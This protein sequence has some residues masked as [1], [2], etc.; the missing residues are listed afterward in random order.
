MPC[1]SGIVYNS[2]PLGHPHSACNTPR[3]TLAQKLVNMSYSGTSRQYPIPVQRPFLPSNGDVS[4]DPI[5][6]VESN[7]RVDGTVDQGARAE[8]MDLGISSQNYETHENI[9]IINPSTFTDSL[10]TIN[11]AYAVPSD[12][13]VS[14]KLYKSHSL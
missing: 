5:A 4:S 7:I 2:V 13:L 1:L 11:P 14:T 8:P 3:I 12:G 10:E 6:L 9:S